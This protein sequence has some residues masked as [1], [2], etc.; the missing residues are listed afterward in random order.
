MTVASPCPT[1]TNTTVVAPEALLPAPP[2]RAEPVGLTGSTGRGGVGVRAGDGSADGRAAR[3]LV[4][5]ADP[6][7]PSSTPTASDRATADAPR[8]CATFR[9]AVP[10]ITG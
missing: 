2:D 4:V 1:S 6:Q 8:S 7:P 10:D 3:A 9:G 5:A